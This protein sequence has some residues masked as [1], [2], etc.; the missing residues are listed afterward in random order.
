MATFPE[1]PFETVIAEVVSSD[2]GQVMEV[3]RAGKGL[4]W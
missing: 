4:G 3:L 2:E 1:D